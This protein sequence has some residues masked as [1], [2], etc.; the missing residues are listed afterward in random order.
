MT[1]RAWT[2]FGAISALWGLPYLLIKVAVAEVEPVT[3]VFIRL[4]ISAAVLL[5]IAAATGSLHRVAQSWKSLVV[6]ATLGIVVPFL[7]IAYGEQHITSSLA[8]LLIAA[9]PLFIVVLAFPFDPAERAGGVR[10]VGLFVGLIGVGVLLGLDVGGDALGVLGAAMVLLAAVCYAASALLVKRLSSVPMLGS[11]TATLSIAGVLLAPIAIANLPR[12]IPSLSALESLVGL[13][14]LCTA[15]GYVIYFS[16]INEAGATGASLITYVNPA[17]AVVLGVV[18]LG[19]PLTPV[20]LVGFGLIVLG[21]ALATGLLQRTR[22]GARPKELSQQISWPR[23]SA[24]TVS[25]SSADKPVFGPSRS[26]PNF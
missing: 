8:A 3:V 1:R 25:G 13:G 10:I 23:S 9:D 2:L 15:L 5:P 21:C 24:Q 22:R 11:V 16:L 19:E 14:L 20:T 17:V 6:V 4:A 18:I 12:Q 26:R 7:L